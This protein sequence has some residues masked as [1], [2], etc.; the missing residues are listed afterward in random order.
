MSKVVQ[1]PA[2]VTAATVIDEA[3]GMNLQ[4][5][6]VLGVTDNGDDYMNANLS[7]GGSVEKVIWLLRRLEH[8]LMSSTDEAG[9]A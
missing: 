7:D 2:P 8:V 3:K 6:V 4:T 9:A 5:V 1:F